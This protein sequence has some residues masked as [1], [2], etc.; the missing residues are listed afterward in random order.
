MELIMKILIV[1]DE[2]LS[3]NFLKLKLSSEAPSFSIAVV[4][5]GAECIEYIQ[6]H[7]VDCI[8]SDFQ[9]PGMDG[10]ELLKTLREQ[11]SD[12]PFIFL[13]GQGNESVA[14]D[15]FKNG[16]W[17]YFTK[18][19]GFAHFTRIIHSITQSVK[20]RDSERLKRMADEAIRNT[21]EG[22]SAK[23]GEDFF[24]SLVQ[25]LAKALGVRY[26]LI[27]EIDHKDPNNARAIALW[28]DGNFVDKFEYDLTNTPCDDV[29]KKE[30]SCFPKDLRKLFPYD[31]YAASFNAESY[32]GAPLRDSSGRVIGILA[33]FDTGQMEDEETV[34]T[35]LKVFASR[36]SVELE[37]LEADRALKETEAKF[38]SLAEQVVVLQQQRADLI[39]AMTR[40][41]F[42]LP[43]IN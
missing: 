4:E 31:A 43:Q 21:A 8:L 30:P 33:V 7:P 23:I 1:D 11:G 34:L 20:Q 17:D 10:M 28:A 18:D 3:G 41:L 40:D 2:E 38:M 13:T 39:A 5:S 27:G 12:I 37:R 14:R 35:I 9:M 15:A 22:V 6:S 29:V 16:A 19:I 26:S 42:A 25:Y 36:A 32:A 24:R